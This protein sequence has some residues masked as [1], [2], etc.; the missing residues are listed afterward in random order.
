M[1]QL[2]HPTATPRAACGLADE[3][4]GDDYEVWTWDHR[5][6]RIRSLKCRVAQPS[7]DFYLQLIDLLT[8]ATDSCEVQFCQLEDHRCVCVLPLPDDGHRTAAVAALPLTATDLFRFAQKASASALKN[9]CFAHETLHRLETAESRLSAFDT[10]IRRSQEELTW[11]HGLACNAALDE[12]GNETVQVAARILPEMRQL[13]RARTVAFIPTP[14]DGAG[15]S[16][17]AVVWQDGDAYVPRHVCLELIAEHGRAATQEA[18]VKNY[19]APVYVSRRFS[20]VLSCIVREVSFST[21]PVGW[22]L[23][24]NK[25]LQHLA[26]EGTWNDLQHSIQAECGFGLFETSLVTAAANALI[27]HARNSNLLAV[28]ETLIDGTIRS[29]V[30]AID[31]KDSYTCGHSDRVAEFA[32]QIAMTMRFSP[33]FCERIYMTGLLHDVGKIGVPDSVLQKPGR[34]TDEEFD[35]IRQH[36]VIGHAILRHL[37]DF[38]YVLPGVLHHH[39][40]VDGSGYP[41]GLKG[42]DIPIEARILAVADAYDAMTSDRPYRAG[43]PS[44]KAEAI[45]ADGAGRQ[46]DSNCV[47]AFLN[48]IDG[49]RRIAH[50]KHDPLVKAPLGY[51]RK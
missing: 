6:H 8:T 17:P 41:H 9:R 28:K 15:K 29:L 1:I 49:I 21:G 18:I 40:A 16:Q 47:T 14:S 22:L 26:D 46:W 10:R 7:V 25:D 34:L 42:D 31:A 27:A 19:D 20:G 35:H 38:S 4:F 39:E 3:L 44:E 37:K 5:W 12:G 30:N 32:R 48:G 43:M 51:L 11:L 24:V 23:A 36:P 2:S 50:E 45:I 33:E 13:I